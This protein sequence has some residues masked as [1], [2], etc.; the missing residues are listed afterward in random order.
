M[1]ELPAGPRSSAG[2]RLPTRVVGADWGTGGDRRWPAGWLR[3]LALVALMSLVKLTA[4]GGDRGADIRLETTIDTVGGVVQVQHAGAAPEW[5]LE[6]V[7]EIGEGGGL[8]EAPSPA[9]FGRIAR[10][11]SDLDGRVYVAEQMP[12]EIRVFGPD[13]S[14]VRTLGRKGAGPGEF[15]GLHG[16]AWLAED[17]MLVADYGNARLARMTVEGEPVG[18]WG[19]VPITGPSKRFLFNG[20]PGEAYVYVIVQGQRGGE[21]LG[22]VWV[23]YA[24]AGAPDTLRIPDEESLGVSLPTNGV[25]CR[26]DGIGFISNQ[27]APSVIARP[28]PGL[29]RAVAVSSEYRIAFLDPVGDTVRV[30]A[31]DVPPVPLPDSIRAAEEAAYQEFRRAWRGADCQGAIAETGVRPVLRDLFFDHHGR[32]LVEYNRPAGVAFDLFDRRG[33]WIATFSAPDR[34]TAIPPYLHGDRLSTVDRDSLDI[35]RVRVHRLV[36]P[37]GGGPILKP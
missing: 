11:I 7:L 3:G 30:I 21:R 24:L 17:T 36:A 25:I 37:A 15:G 18:Q 32:L 35:Q 22:S 4:C 29:Q 20:G 1:A 33:R 34:D 31:R 9:E 10:V 19:W 16:M 28:A 6:P 12:P 2:R 8:T 26:G 13:G 14:H 27:Y 23:R 5:R